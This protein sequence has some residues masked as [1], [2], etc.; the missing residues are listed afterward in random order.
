MKKRWLLALL[1]SSATS[2]AGATAQS[3][4]AAITNS[5]S[6]NTL[7]YTIR[8]WSNGGADITMRGATPR[9]FNLDDDLAGRFFTDVKAARDNPGSPSHCMKSASF[10]TST[11]VTWHGWSSADLQ[12]PPMTAP[13]NA[14]AQDVRLIQQAANIDTKIRRFPLPHD[15][16]MIPTAAP[17][18]TPT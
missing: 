10:G 5:G 6:T 17:E 13:M 4:G 8:V 14:L 16:R 15:L 3:D 2:I 11:S 18:V 7:G 9:A 12:C 1:L